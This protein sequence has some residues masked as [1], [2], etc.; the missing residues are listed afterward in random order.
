MIFKNISKKIYLYHPNAIVFWL[1][2]FGL[3]F[4][5]ISFV[6]VSIILIIYIFWPFQSYD[7]Q[8]TDIT[9]NKVVLI[10]HG[11]KDDTAT[12]VTTLKKQLLTNG[13]DVQVIAIDWSRYADNALTCSVNGRRIG[14]DM[15]NILLKNSQLID[16]QLIGHSCGAFV[17]YG[18]CE[19]LKEHQND[20]NV[21]SI[22]L[23]PVSVYGGMFWEFGLDNFG[24]CANESITYFDTEDRVPGSNRAPIHSTGIDVTDYK[25]QFGFDGA[26]HQWPIYYFLAINE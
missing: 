14:H 18:I 4:P 2:F 5:V 12:W 23:A 7:I 1:L 10:S 15:A 20:I 26:P 19:V 9:S 21:N 22:Y 11:L 6:F 16:I 17:N 3:Y 8:T 13:G 24:A 25:Q